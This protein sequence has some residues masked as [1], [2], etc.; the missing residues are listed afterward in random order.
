MTLPKTA[1]IH[2]VG[3]RDGLQNEKAPVSTAA[4]IELV[5][6]LA[7]AGLPSIEYGSFVSPK[8]VP[9]MADSDEVGRLITRLPGISYQALVMNMKGYERAKAVG[10]DSVNIVTGVS[11]TFN[12]KNMNAGVD[13]SLENYR[14]IIAQARQDGIQITAYVST[15]FGC[16]YEG[17]VAFAE[18]LTVS[19]KFLAMGADEVIL[20]DTIGCAY[21]KQV[22]ELI[23]LHL[24][25]IPANKLGLHFH[26]TRG[27]ALANV[28][29]VLQMGVNRF[30]GSVGGMGGCP[31]APGAQGNVCTE[32]LVFMLEEMGVE[33]GVNVPALIEVSRTV[34]GLL[35]RSLPGHIKNAKH[36]PSYLER[37]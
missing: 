22:S 9:Q 21:P 10:M 8:W 13:E 6:A 14:P 29:A 30:D 2:E 35:G 33:T 23:A 37:K 12:R 32:D 28:L 31:F 26:D 19:R 27:L 15:A 4:K 36:K 34:E 3:P 5:N 17:D 18:A 20:S 24:E 16:P 25:H 11:E 1:K 7:R